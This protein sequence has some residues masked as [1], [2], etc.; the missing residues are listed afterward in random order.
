MK[1]IY[2]ILAAMTLL[3]MSLNAQ[4]K[5][6]QIER[7]S[8]H[9]APTEKF[10]GNRGSGSLRASTTPITP[11]YT[12]Y[13]EYFDDFWEVIDVRGDGNTWAQYDDSDRYSARYSYSSSYAADDWLVTPPVYLEAGK[14]YKF[15]IDARVYSSNYP[16][17]M[18]V[19]LASGHTASA[20]SN[21]TTVIAERELTNTSYST[22]ANDGVTVSTSGYYYFGIHATSAKNQYYLYVS[23]FAIK[24]MHDLAVYLSAPHTSNAGGTVT[25]VATVY[26]PGASAETG[27]SIN[28]TANG[29]SIETRMFNTPLAAGDVTT[30]PVEYTSNA[31]DEGQ[32]VNFGATL[33]C[34][35][36]DNP[37]NNTTTTSTLLT[38]TA[39]L[40][41]VNVQATGGE[42]SG[43]MRWN[44]PAIAPE[45]VT[46]DFEYAYVFP[47]F[48]TGGITS[49]VHTG[50]FGDW[51][52]Y[53][54]TGAP[55]YGSTDEDFPN[56]G[57]PHAWFVFNPT[58]MGSSSTAHSGDQYLETVCPLSSYG[59]SNHWLI[60][61][62]LS[63]N[64]QTITFYDS[65]FTTDWGEEK[66]TVWVST[67]DN[68][69]SS[70]TQRIGNYSVDHTDW[71]L[72]TISLPA[73]AKYFAIQ[74][75]SNNVFGLRIDD[76]T[77]K[78][79]PVN[80]E[81][82]NVYL[83]GQFVVNVDSNTFTY[84]FSNVSTGE[85]QCAVSAV[86]PD[87][88]ESELE[89]ATFTATPAVPVLTAPENGT[90][91]NVGTNSG[92]GAKKDIT[93][94]GANLTE[95][96]TVSVSGT[97]FRVSPTTL[98]ADAV[99]GGT[100]ITV[101]Y[102]GTNPN[103]QGTLTISSG[104]VSV[105]VNLTASYSTGIAP[106]VHG[107]VRMGTLPIVDQF[108]EKIPDTNDHPY[109][110]TYFL[111]L[112]ARDTITS[113][114]A[115]VPVQHTGADI[116]GYYYKAQMK[117][118][119]DPTNFLAP[120]ML[121]AEVDMNLSP[122][123]AP[124][125]Y[126]I[127][128]V[129]N[130]VPSKADD[131]TSYLS[132]LQRREAGDYQEMQEKY[133][134]EIENP[135][136]KK[137]YESGK[138]DFVDYRTVTAEA[139]TDYLSYAPIVWTKGIDRHYY[140]SDSLHNSYGAPLWEVRAG[141]VTMDKPE[142]ERMA[143]IVN[144]QVQWNP[145][146]NWY[147][148]NNQACSQFAVRS[149]HATGILPVGNIEYEP[150]MFRL[151]VICDGLRNFTQDPKTGE[152]VNDPDADRTSP[153]L[154]DTKYCHGADDLSYDIVIDYNDMTKNIYFGGL[155]NIEPTFLVR[156]YYVV[157]GYQ[158]PVDG[159]R[160]EAD[161]HVG[162]VAEVEGD[163]DDP[164]TAIVELSPDAVVVEQIFYNVQGMQSDKPFDGINIVV[165][166]YS[167]GSTLTTKVV[168]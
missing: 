96:L 19:K 50:A 73:G 135:Y 56:E 146:V 68:N 108:A 87:G 111:Q 1:K 26:N 140:T 72:R 91:V 14:I 22:L 83:D 97:G 122:A 120:N 158:E 5:V 53:D 131:Y 157:K 67:T 143:K 121:T 33:T 167:D 25:M 13:F 95:N 126:T 24:R 106:T 134:N 42:Q 59:A 54:P 92:L 118:D 107:M 75:T 150:Y 27:Y 6:D 79:A 82:Y 58:L 77:Y 152:A 124:Y 94:S 132:V 139:S 100:T 130:G 85:H 138:Y 160:A 71:Q 114:P 2:M 43:T 61:P 148:E 16:E 52:L 3:S 74:H 128:S 129:K 154:L 76:I 101:T 104:E 159:S 47:P 149:I 10:V 65:E 30:F 133:N 34:D 17:K 123:S 90:T 165:T 78:A 163:P 113:S 62:E 60:S 55:V 9:K 41:P 21:G 145:Y 162:Y 11:P 8:Q 39:L 98:T 28:F 136:L 137:T 70:F 105:T 20:L 102:I 112:A 115:R 15:S 18:E 57:E 32:T 110:Y 103:A 99:N 64:A 161:D 144:G 7:T 38:T 86:Y 142:F 88:A 63:G 164:F 93:V 153:R 141:S 168:R 117:G 12:D 89:P 116:Q 40:P 155:N 35:D 80:P 127:N 151:W 37:V 45:S 147:D 23:N 109:R 156:F 69:P 81:Y 49:T 31:S 66:F 29:T 119:T 84:T 166:R 51:G 36:D 4:T 46:E 44:A 125:F 48:S